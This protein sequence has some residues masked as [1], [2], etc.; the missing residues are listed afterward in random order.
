MPSGVEI[1]GFL[2]GGL[3]LSCCVTGTSKRRC[4]W[5]RNWVKAW[6]WNGLDDAGLKRSFVVVSACL[7]T[8]WGVGQLNRVKA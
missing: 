4:R 5:R 3:E 1:G 6:C 2:G 8:V 7:A